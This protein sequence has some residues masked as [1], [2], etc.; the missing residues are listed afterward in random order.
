M[1]QEAIRS[2]VPWRDE[3]VIDPVEVVKGRVGLPTR[4]GLGIEVNE[5]AAREHPFEPEIL[6]QPFH[7]DGAVADW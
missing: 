5:A 1:I 7:R 4:P 3:V 6:V 2:D